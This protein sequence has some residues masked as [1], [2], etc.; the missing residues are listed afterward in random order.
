MS[1][2]ALALGAIA[3][4]VAGGAHVVRIATGEGGE[5]AVV[6]IACFTLTVVV[7]TWKFFQNA[8]QSSQTA[9]AR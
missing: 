1:Q 7:S 4:F 8:R 2:R 6:A 5:L 3:S 9:T